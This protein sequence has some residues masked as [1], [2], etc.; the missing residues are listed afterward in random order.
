MAQRMWA[1]RTWIMVP[2]LAVLGMV[3]SYI[4]I[5]KSGTTPHPTLIP[6]TIAITVWLSIMLC[7]GATFFVPLIAQFFLPRTP[8]RQDEIDSVKGVVSRCIV[9]DVAPDTPTDLADRPRVLVADA[10]GRAV[11]GQ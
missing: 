10:E 4:L 8:I 3:I 6:A 7:F 1:R 5:N 9:R 11:A 2:L